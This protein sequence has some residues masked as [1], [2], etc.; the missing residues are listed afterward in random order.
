MMGNN[1]H[2]HILSLKS[3]QISIKF[4]KMYTEILCD[5]HFGSFTFVI[6]PYFTRISYRIYRLYEKLTHD[7]RHRSHPDLQFLCFEHFS[8]WCIN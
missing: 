6:N 2:S 8:V 5:F 1:I 3:R 7:V 4:D